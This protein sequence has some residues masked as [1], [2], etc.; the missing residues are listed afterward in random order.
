MLRNRTKPSL[1][2]ARFKA[3]ESIYGS[4]PDKLEEIRKLLAEA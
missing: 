3:D 1:G 2:Q 4:F